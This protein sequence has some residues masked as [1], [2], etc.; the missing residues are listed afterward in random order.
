MALRWAAGSA[1]TDSTVPMK[2]ALPGRKYSQGFNC[3]HDVARA[4]GTLPVS[5]IMCTNHRLMFDCTWIVDATTGPRV[6]TPILDD[7]R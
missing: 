6:P 3:V 5:K 1:S 2:I 4:A 7:C